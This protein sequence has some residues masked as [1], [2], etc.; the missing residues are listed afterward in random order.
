MNIGILSMQKIINFG[1]FL[2]SYA[3]KHIL[4][5][6]GHS[7]SFV[8]IKP[9]EKLFGERVTTSQ[10]NKFVIDKYFFKR[11]EHVIF[12]KKRKKRFLNEFFPSIGIDMPLDEKQCDMLVVGSDEVFNCCQKENWGFSLQLMG[13]TECPSISYAGS[14]GFTDYNMLTDACIDKKVASAMK[15]F[16]SISVRDNNSAIC[17]NKLTGI[18]PHI[19]LDP[20][21]IYDWDK[22]LCPQTKYNNYILIY[23]Y[24]NRINNENEI[25]AI[26]TFAKKHKKKLISFGVYQRWCD[27]NVSCTPLELISYFDGADYVITDTFHGTVISVKRNKK[28]VT[29]I[30]ESNT[31]KISDLLSKFNLTERTMDNIDSLENI[32]TKDIDYICVNNIIKEEQIKSISYLRE[33]L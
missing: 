23:S 33:N 24:D 5:S 26:K 31:N 2:Q 30:R 20:V 16:K 14:F 32:I 3:L 21:L 7:V 19:H 10:K 28:F 25:K 12:Y 6:M 4:E 18:E 8:D 11:I 17:V 22:D 29:I 9:G 13:E 27:L 1:S 15:R